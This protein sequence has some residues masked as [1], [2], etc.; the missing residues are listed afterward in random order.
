MQSLLAVSLVVNAVLLLPCRAVDGVSSLGFS[1]GRCSCLCSG[2][3]VV[4]FRSSDRQAVPCQVEV[5]TESQL[6]GCLCG[7][8]LLVSEASHSAPLC[9]GQSSSGL[10]QILF[11]LCVRRLNRKV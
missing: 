2:S 8:S 1:P 4:G 9:S 3:A 6:C 11:P 7:C 5:K 10:S